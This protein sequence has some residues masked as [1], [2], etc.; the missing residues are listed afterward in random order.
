MVYAIGYDPKSKTL[1]N[2]GSVQ[3]FRNL[4]PFFSLGDRVKK[5]PGGLGSNLL[6][7]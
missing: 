1:R 2:K 5:W 7:W 6:V 4:L 3:E